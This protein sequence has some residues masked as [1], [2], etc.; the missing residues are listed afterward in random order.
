M[1]VGGGILGPWIAQSDGPTCNRVLGR[2]DLLGRDGIVRPPALRYLHVSV[3][4]W[5]NVQESRELVDPGV[6][7]VLPIDETREQSDATSSRFSDDVA[8]DR[9]RHGQSPSAF[10][11]RLLEFAQLPHNGAL[12][13]LDRN[14]SFS[15]SIVDYGLRVPPGLRD[16]LLNGFVICLAHPLARVQSVVLGQGHPRL[17]QPLFEPAEQIGQGSTFVHHVTQSPASLTQRLVDLPPIVTVKPQRKRTL[18][19]NEQ[20][21]QNCGPL[22]GVLSHSAASRIQSLKIF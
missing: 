8:G 18:T 1:T 22:T 16:H 19:G 21:L 20:F 12:G 13:L 10:A 11:F 6:D 9:S 14:T 5:Q 15:A 7:L 4:R 17:L 3:E 2:R